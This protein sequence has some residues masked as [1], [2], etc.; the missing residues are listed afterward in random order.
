MAFKDLTYRLFGED[1]SASKA[2]EHV[3]DKAEGAGG[4]IAQLGQKLESWGV[5]FGSSIA[6]AGEK[7]DDLDTK[8]KKASAI[9]Q[10]VGKVSMLAFA[11]GA[12]GAAAESIHLAMNYQQATDAIAAGSGTSIAAATKVSEAFLHTGFQ[13]T[14]SAQQI[15]TAYAGVA[16]QLTLTEGHALT[17]SQA[18]TVMGSAIDLAEASGE[19]LSSTTAGLA[20]VMQ[21]FSLRTDQASYAADTLWTVAKDTNNS[22]AGVASGVAKLHARLGDLA[23]SLTDSASAMVELAEHGITGTRSV[24]LF[25]SAMTTLVGGSKATNKEL[26]DLGVKVYDSSGKFVGMRQVI[27]EL[28]P[29]LAGMTEQQRN[30]ALATLFGKGAAQVMGEVLASGVSKWDE[31]AKSV[32][33][34]GAAHAAAALATA[35]LHAQGEKLISGLEDLGV[36]VGNKLLPYLTDLG[37]ETFKVTSYFEKHAIAGKVV[38]AVI[39]GVLVAAMSAYV[40]HL[41]VVAYESLA[42]FGQMIASGATWAAQTVLKV[43]QVAATYAW[44]YGSQMAEWVAS[45]ARTVAATLALGATWVVGKVAQAATVVASN[46]ASAAATAAAW[47][48]A[49]IAMIAASGGILLAIGALV[50]GAYELVKHWHQV[51]TDIKH[52]VDDAWQFIKQHLVWVAAAFGPIGLAIYELATHWHEVWGGIKAVIGDAWGFIHTAIGDI[53]HL[54]IDWIGLEVRGLEA[55]WHD[56]WTGIA[57]TVHAVWSVLAPIFHAIGSAVSGVV[58]SISKVTGIAGSIGHAAGGWMHAHGFDKGGIVPGPKGAPLLAVVHGGEYVVSN[59]MMAGAQGVGAG[60]PQLALGGS[61]AG[62]TV[63]VYMPNGYMTGTPMQVAQQLA[64][65]LRNAKVNGVQLG[66]S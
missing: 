62:T 18:M 21:A 5:P 43:Y 34:A 33:K 20:Q 22:V 7:F 15:A 36:T 10:E 57:D 16:G 66:L 9:L 29:R 51:W 42:K 4:R 46:V 11:A 17:A 26:S 45:E 39:G 58:G 27:A 60:G 23:P 19:S 14:M 2:M 28:E 13:T 35:N 25:S 24:S 37:N 47:V 65:L 31:T 64:K 50:L 44:Y 59:D 30:A 3:A 48:A 55:L 49:N 54:G 56:V 38:A 40:A 52:W 8:G 1:V 6:K 63:N 32:A 61:G 41:A 53:V 12:A